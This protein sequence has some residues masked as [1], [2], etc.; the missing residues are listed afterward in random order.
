MNV[1]IVGGD[2]LAKF[3]IQD[4]LEFEGDKVVDDSKNK[5]D[6]RNFEGYALAGET[7][8]LCFPGQVPVD[9]CTPSYFLVG[10]W[11]GREFT[12]QTALGIPLMGT[13]GEG[14]GFPAPMGCAARFLCMN[15][16]VRGIF[17]TKS[18]HDLLTNIGWNGFVSLEMRGL[19]VCKI[20]IGA[21]C[22]L[23]YA[24]LEGRRGILSN[25]ILNKFEDVFAESWTTSLLVSC[26]PYPSEERTK[27]KALVQGLNRFLR[28][29]FWPFAPTGILKESFQTNYSALGVVTSFDRYLR[30]AFDRAMGTCQNI[31][32]SWKQYRQDGWQV[33]RVRK[34]EIDQLIT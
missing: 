28:K 27:E 11:N 7:V 1:Q 18:F 16:T 10:I 8:E 14:L 13:G 30:E 19:T 4:R 34:L 29:H 20:Y 3:A 15:D 33:A 6:M 31:S 21:P 32:V 17:N 23:A 12:P 2:T 22:F 5:L 25:L 26:F 9:H 24:L